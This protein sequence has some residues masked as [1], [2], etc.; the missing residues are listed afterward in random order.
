MERCSRLDEILLG[1]IKLV[2][3]VGSYKIVCFSFI[4]YV[5]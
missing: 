5:N 3:I 1:D 2:C 4:V